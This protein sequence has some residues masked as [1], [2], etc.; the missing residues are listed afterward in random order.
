MGRL[1]GSGCRVQSVTKLHSGLAQMTAADYEERRCGFCQKRLYDYQQKYCSRSCRQRFSR[2]R[3]G[4][5]GLGYRT[6]W[7]EVCD[8]AKANPNHWIVLPSFQSKQAAQLCA[9]NFNG[10]AGFQATVND[11]VVSIRLVEAR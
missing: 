8:Q 5:T 9:V 10:K 1:A 3:R 11:F 2:A 7:R 6:R 4:L